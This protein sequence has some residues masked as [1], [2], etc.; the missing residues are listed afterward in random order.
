MFDHD[1]I[2]RLASVDDLPANVRDEV[3]ERLTRS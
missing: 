2:G 3:E 1:S